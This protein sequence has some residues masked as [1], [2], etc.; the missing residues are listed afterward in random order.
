MKTV[1]AFLFLFSFAHAASEQ[2]P[3]VEIHLQDA[4][5]LTVD[6]YK[7]LPSPAREPRRPVPKTPPRKPAPSPSPSRPSNP[8]PP[9]FPEDLTIS[10]G[11]N[12]S[13]HTWFPWDPTGANNFPTSPDCSQDALRESIWRTSEPAPQGRNIGDWLNRCN[14]QIGS[15]LSRHSFFPLIKYAT[16]DYDFAANEN[17]HAVLAT[18]PDGRKLRGFIAMKPG[19]VR[20]PF[21][22]A[23]CGVLCNATQSTTHRAFM[24]HLYDESPFHVLT[25]A[26]NSGTDFVK[27]NQ[28]FSVGGFDEGRQLYQIAQ[29]V[30][31]A[32][33]PIRDRISSVH[34]V[35]ASLG[36]SAALYSGVYSSVNDPSGARAIQSV[37]GVCPVVVV[38]SSAKRLYSARPI[39]T[40]ASFETVHQIRDIFGFIP[41]FNKVFGP[42]W[43]KLRGEKLY[44]KVCDA[45]YE[46]YHD[47]TTKHPWDSKPFE[48]VKID[49]MKQFWELND[50]RNYAPLVRIPTM[51]VA[52]ENDD[53]VRVDGN[54]KLLTETLQKENNEYISTEY[55]K[56][57]N[58]CAFGVANGWGNYSMLLREYIL[59]HSPEARDHW[60]SHTVKLP[61]VSVRLIQGESIVQATWLAR[62]GDE[63]MWL[64]LKIFGPR[65]IGDS[66]V[67]D[68]E[69]RYHADPRCYRDAK[70]AIPL[71]ALPFGG[72][73]AGGGGVPETKFAATSLT[74]FANTRFSLSDAG[75]K[76]VVDTTAMP[77]SVRVWDWE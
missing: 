46:Y 12:G 63:N 10:E 68:W 59:S 1:I 24:M 69:H 5:G 40:V 73:A 25:L 38:E 75:G 74:R 30:R 28:A 11:A 72:D 50:F 16:I 14:G 34:V 53:L 9:D 18:L 2:K 20:R 70:V 39:S 51:T 57:G 42:N 67:C 49:S 22:I 58:H 66:G 36:G 54:T 35:G 52:A 71:R 8:T 32:D 15:A 7:R 26:N 3:A 56:Q 65:M 41:F 23:K 29:L 44:G 27:D 64:K 60:R 37:T 31:S 55:F 43:H 77:S 45:I 13:K 76:T 61:P 48:G 19:N 21:V 4:S 17:I 6:I 62:V 47:W 33:S